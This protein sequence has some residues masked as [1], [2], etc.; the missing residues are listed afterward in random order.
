MAHKT[1]SQF[2]PKGVILSMT[3]L[4]TLL[5]T[6]VCYNPKQ[7]SAPHIIQKDVYPI[8]K[9]I[10]YGFTVVNQSNTFI[11]KSKL[12]VYAPV[13][14]TSIQKTETID[15]SH[16]YILTLDQVGNQVLEFDLNNMPPHGRKLITID[17]GLTLTSSPNLQVLLDKTP[18]LTNAQYVEKND[19]LILKIANTIKGNSE[20]EL[21]ESIYHWVASNIKYAGYIKEDRGARYAALNK[22]GDCTEYMYLFMALSRAKGIPVRGLGGYVYRDNSMLKPSDYHNWAE[23]YVEGAW[24]LVDPQK[25]NYMNNSEKYIAMRIIDNTEDSKLT[26]SQRFKF[27][28]DRLTVKMNSI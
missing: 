20:T 11:P 19:P 2:K 18:Y 27:S 15:S 21:S 17:A 22:K 3:F 1:H 24:R 4:V 8:N 7:S 12:W 25:K 10:R 13:K 5:V 28:D 14:K 6:M 26:S 23:V 9:S 16:P